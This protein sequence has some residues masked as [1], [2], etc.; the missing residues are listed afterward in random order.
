MH[1]WQRKF[2]INSSVPISLASINI[3][4]VWL[5]LL[6]CLLRQFQTRATSTVLLTIRGQRNLV[7]HSSSIQW[8]VLIFGPNV[9]GHRRRN[10]SNDS[11]VFMGNCFHGWSSRVIW[12]VAS[13]ILLCRFQRR[14]FIHQL[15]LSLVT[16]THSIALSAHQCLAGRS[17]N[18][19]Y[20]QGTL[21][22][23]SSFQLFIGM[24]RNMHLHWL[25]PCIWLILPIPLLMHWAFSI[26]QGVLLREFS[27]KSNTMLFFPLPPLWFPEEEIYSSFGSNFVGYCR[28]CLFGNSAPSLT[29]FC[30]P[31]MSGYQ[32]HNCLTV[33]FGVF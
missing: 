31:R 29:P 27:L 20:S 13:T 1:N 9:I 24:R 23:C 32:R 30:G 2:N 11:S 17:A 22:F 14:K 8:R 28:S 5:A 10:C 12:C 7:I 25:S 33:L 16:V 15:Q 21:I 19:P 6:R 4:A 3:P 18:V 26:C